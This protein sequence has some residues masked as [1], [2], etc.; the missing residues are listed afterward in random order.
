MLKDF[1]LS[2]L[3]A[4]FLAV[5]I[6][7]AGPMVL[8][9]QAAS[10]AQISTEMMITWVWAISIGAAVS[11]IVLSTLLKVPVITAWSAPGSALLIT[12]FPAL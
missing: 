5:L 4:G 3:T 10:A 11:G 7:Y 6:S 2:A 9:F 8:M 1:S 12:L